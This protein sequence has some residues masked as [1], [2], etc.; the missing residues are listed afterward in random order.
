MKKITLKELAGVLNMS[1][2]TVSRALSDHP[3]ISESTKQKVKDASQL[4][5]YTPNLRARYLRTKSSGL[6]ALILPEYNMFFIPNLMKAI[7][8]VVNDHNYSLLV[9][10]SDD[11]YEKELDIIEYCNQISV[12][13][14]LL[15]IGTGFDHKKDLMELSSEGAPIVLL[16][17]V[18]PN[19]RISHVSIEGDVISEKA[20]RYLKKMGHKDVIGVFSS[21]ELT[22]TKARYKGFK[23]SLEEYD[24]EIKGKATF[25]SKL[26]ELELQLEAA[27]K[28]YPEATALYVMSDELVM[29]VYYYLQKSG[30]K[31]PDEL[32]VVSISDGTLPF[33]VYPQLTHFYHSP[34]KIGRKAAEVLFDQI[35]SKESE[36]RDIRIECELVQL[37]SVKNIKEED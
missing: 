22:I 25:V 19:D 1:V 37:G 7:S 4:Y 10:Q 35:K 9:F 14:I 29:R 12:D 32:S 5:N 11:S 15:S 3:D 24:G 13:G 26:D 2:S 21:E 36:V 34:A 17:R 6:V 31:V 20:L 33:I 16:D 30:I 23:E 28:D 8:E 18:W 27:L